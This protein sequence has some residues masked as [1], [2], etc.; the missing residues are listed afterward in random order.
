ML[1][2]TDLDRSIEWCVF[3]ATS[4]GRCWTS[5]LERVP[6]PRPPHQR[7]LSLRSVLALSFRY[8]NVLGCKLLRTRVNEQYNYTLAFLAFGEEEDSCVF[9]LTY[10]H[11]DHTYT[12]GDA[13]AQVAISTKDVYRSAEDI[14]AKGGNIVREPGPVAGHWHEDREH[15]RS[16]WLEDCAG[17][18]GGF[19]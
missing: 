2:V 16:G 7:F 14:R 5:L 3:E 13:Y 1:R 17:R 11:G 4:V 9:E 8:T 15:P 12:P 19:S 6:S 18:R 10:N